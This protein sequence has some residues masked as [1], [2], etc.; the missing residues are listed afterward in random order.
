MSPE[1]MVLVKPESDFAG[2]LGLGDVP[3]AFDGVEVAPPVD[4]AISL[5]FDEVA[6]LR[7]GLSCNGGRWWPAPMADL[8]APATLSCSYPDLVGFFLCDTPVRQLVLRGQLLG[9]PGQLSLLAYAVGH[10]QWRS[11][12]EDRRAAALASIDLVGGIVWLPR[13]EPRDGA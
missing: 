6:Q 4:L 11:F 5:R 9:T 13:T 10:D 3:F 12:V 2:A 7:F 1:P 8:R